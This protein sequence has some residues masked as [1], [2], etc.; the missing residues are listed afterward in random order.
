MGSAVEH[1]EIIYFVNSNHTL[2]LLHYD[3]AEMAI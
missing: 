2:L 3:K 1:V